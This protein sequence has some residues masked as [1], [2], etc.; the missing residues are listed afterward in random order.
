MLR[1]QLVLAPRS[2][3]RLVGI[4]LEGPDTE[5]GKRYIAGRGRGASGSYA[6]GVDGIF[7]SPYWVHPKGGPMLRDATETGHRS[8]WFAPTGSATELQSTV[9]HEF[10]H[11]VVSGFTAHDGMEPDMARQLLPTLL[12]TLGG[13]DGSATPDLLDPSETVPT[14]RLDQWVEANRDRLAELVSEYGASSFHELL[15][16][17]WAEYSTMGDEA[18][19]HI[20]II[21]RLMHE[22]AEGKQP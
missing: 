14:E 16:E 7:L 5:G 20:N 11:H 3:S 17:I 15:A 18:R 12:E 21:G 1:H 2:A 9:A 4:V 13:S 8:G 6:W 19:P 10:G 22:L